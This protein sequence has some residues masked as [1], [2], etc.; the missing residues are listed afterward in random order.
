MDY[1]VYMSD[2]G[3]KKGKLGAYKNH[4]VKN[5]EKIG[6]KKL[7]I[8]GGGEDYG[9]LVQALSQLRTKGVK[10]PDIAFRVTAYEDR[11]SADDDIKFIGE[12]KGKA[13]SLFV[14]IIAPF[15]PLEIQLAGMAGIP[16]TSAAIAGALKAK[17]GFTEDGYLEL[18]EPSG[19]GM[20]LANMKLNKGLSSDV[21]RAGAME[22]NTAQQMAVYKDKMKGQ[23]CFI[24]GHYNAKL[25]E[26]NGLM[27]EHAFACNE[28]CDFFSRTPQ[29][30]E[31]FVLT[32][33]SS[34]LGNGKY[35]E[36]MESFIDG[37]IKVFEDKFKKKP[38]YFNG[39]GAGLISGLPGFGEAESVYPTA[40]IFPLYAMI[41]LALY[42][43]FREIYLYGWDGLFT[44]N[45]DENGIGRKPADG[46][47][48]DFPAAARK[49]M[50]QIKSYA[51][52]NGSEII[53]MCST[54]G[55]SML[56]HVDFENIELSSSSIIG[57]L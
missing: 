19:L 52:N 8:A 15:T 40:N 41:Q 23:R 50:E 29:R 17:C 34:Y 36:G 28:F 10:V 47:A 38:S 3:M 48:A 21:K 49:L 22:N 1:S 43:G 55:F 46:E 56:K 32:K 13:S 12:L 5:I 51:E 6:Q 44:L 20:T 39:L 18:N 25:D 27:N 2:E 35:I 14:L 57:R 9:V 31:F 54:N 26:L 24:M 4:I 37:R 45:I 53:S 7:V 16:E 11:A 30:P 33:E 42:M